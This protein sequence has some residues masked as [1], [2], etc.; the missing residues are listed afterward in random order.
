MEELILT[1]IDRRYNQAVWSKLNG[2]FG[3]VLADKYILEFSNDGFS[4]HLLCEVG[5]DFGS[6]V[7]L[8]V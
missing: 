8:D 5:Q 1:K 3:E 4:L 7:Y 2:L 6:K